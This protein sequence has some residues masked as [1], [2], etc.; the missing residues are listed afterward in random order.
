MDQDKTLSYYEQQMISNYS[1]RSIHQ[2]DHSGQ[3]DTTQNNQTT[4]I[5]KY[6]EID[7]TTPDNR[8]R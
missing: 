1:E 7:S 8:K 5:L 2:H 4:N 3:E 6:M